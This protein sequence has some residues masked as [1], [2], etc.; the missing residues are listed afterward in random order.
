MGNEKYDELYNGKSERINNLKLSNIDK[1]K[2]EYTELKFSKTNNKILLS[3]TLISSITCQV[4]YFVEL[5]VLTVCTAKSKESEKKDIELKILT[6][7]YVDL[8][9]VG[10]IFLMILAIS[11]VYLMILFDFC[12]RDI[13]ER[14]LIK[15][16]S[17]FCGCCNEGLGKLCDKCIDIFKIDDIKTQKVK[18]RKDIVVLEGNIKSLEEFQQILKNGNVKIKG[19]HTSMKKSHSKYFK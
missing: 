13:K 16:N 5:I 9:I 14:L 6:S 12:G 17:L 2:Y 18:I 15:E 11:Y 8:L 19:L 3:I 7:T 1:K 4:M 10:Y